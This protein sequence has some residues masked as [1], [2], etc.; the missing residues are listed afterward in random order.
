MNFNKHSHL[1][2]RH[3][4]LSAS[5]YPWVRYSEEKLIETFVK[6]QAAARGTRLHALA[7]DLIRE[8]IKLPGN[9]QT[10][11]LYV[12]DAIG[13][14][15][16]PEQML[17]YSDNIFGTTDAIAFRRNKL[18][19]YDYKSGET[20]PKIDQLEIY[21]AL[22]CLEYGVKPMDIEID[23]RIYFQN[24]ALMFEADKHEITRIMS[25]II[26]FDKIIEEL[27]SEL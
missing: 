5:K 18:R 6:S 22:F 3:A 24:E 13:Y 9:G 10:L 21:S 27:K 15:M 26:T 4:F 25:Q 1:A 8:G 2:G 23:L 14:R 11:S 19:I 12:N 16:A 20:E 7:H 17:Y